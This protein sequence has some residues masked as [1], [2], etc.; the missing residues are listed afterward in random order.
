VRD[1]GRQ[2]PVGFLAGSMLAGFALARFAGSASP[3]TS[4]RSSERLEAQTRKAFSEEGGADGDGT[5]HTESFDPAP[6]RDASSEG[7]WRTDV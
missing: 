1:F 3:P 5:T 6:P 7:T 4:P 2:N